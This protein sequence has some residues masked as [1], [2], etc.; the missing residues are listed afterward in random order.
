ME[1]RLRALKDIH[2]FYSKQHI[3]VT[4]NFDEIDASMTTLRMGEWM[5]LCIEFGVMPMVGKNKLMEIFKTTANF[6]SKP[7]DFE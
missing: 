1:K 4:G 3:P 7:L 6:S 2:M 5:R